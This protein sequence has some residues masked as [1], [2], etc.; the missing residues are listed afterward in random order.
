MGAARRALA[1]ATNY[2]HGR[3]AFGGTIGD[4]QSVQMKLAHLRSEVQVCTTFIDRCISDLCCG[5][6][7]TES[8]S[9]AKYHATETSFR[10]ADS[11]AQLF[12]GYGYLKNSPIGKI[13]VDQRVVRVYGGS[14]E[15]QLEIVSRG[16]GFK[17]Q[18]MSSKL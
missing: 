5:K 18:R 4:L 13:M 16:L 9:M 2:V 14:N 11:C 10:V 15:V 7:S 3:A 1:L 8:A 12:G 17:P 6:L